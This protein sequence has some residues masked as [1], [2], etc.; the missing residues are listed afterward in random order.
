MHARVTTFTMD[1]SRYD[2]IK[3]VLEGIK[4]QIDSLPGL[5]QMTNTMDR[6]TGEGTVVAIYTD[7]DAANANMENVQA[8]W[9]NFAD[10]MTSEP[11]RAIHEVIHMYS[12]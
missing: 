10:Y 5:V 6:E 9:G 12:S 2:E 11:K 8:I 7:A 1:V 3:G 4:D